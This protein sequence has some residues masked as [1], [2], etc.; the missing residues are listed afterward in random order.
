MRTFVNSANSQGSPYTVSLDTVNPGYYLVEDSANR[1][2]NNWSSTSSSQTFN[3]LA[4]NCG[5]GVTI[6]VEN[7]VY[8]V[9]STWTVA[10]INNVTLN[11]ERGSEL[12]AGNNLNSPALDFSKSN[13]DVVN[14]IVINGNAVNQAVGTYPLYSCGIVIN[15]WN[16]EVSDATISDCRVMGIM[17]TTGSHS[18]VVNSEIYDCGW[19][20][21]DVTG[22]NTV[23]CYATDNVVY[24]CSDVGITTYGTYT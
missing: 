17:I 15:G 8:K 23:N 11:F 13:N 4:A 3:N 16:D 7:G 12:V 24:G 18:G 2:V 5:S 21:I 9:T 14:S 10:N 22:A 19:N 6:D 1:I 20:G